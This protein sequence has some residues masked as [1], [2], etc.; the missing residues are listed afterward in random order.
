M[1]GSDSSQQNAEAFFL[2]SVRNP[3]RVP[4]LL[5]VFQVLRVMVQP[6]RGQREVFPAQ[7]VPQDEQ[8]LVQLPQVAPRLFTQLPSC[9]VQVV[10]VL[11]AAAVSL[12]AQA[13]GGKSGRLKNSL[14]HA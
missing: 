4:P 11:A 14:Q 1:D 2:R 9:V 6:Q 8:V 5:C 7:V 12:S 3:L 10:Q 13:E